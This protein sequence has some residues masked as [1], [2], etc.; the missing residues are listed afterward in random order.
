MSIRN[1]KRDYFAEAHQ[2]LRQQGYKNYIQSL[3]PG[4]KWQNNEY[5]VLNPTRNDTTPSSFSINGTSGKWADFATDKAGNDLIG[6]TA[7]IRNITPIEACFYIGAR[8]HN[9]T[10]S[11]TITEYSTSQNNASQNQKENNMK[12][13]QDFTEELPPISQEILDEITALTEEGRDP[14]E[15]LSA[16][17]PPAITAADTGHHNE[18]TFK[19]FPSAFFPYKN[20]LGVTVGYIVRWDVQTEGGET[21]KGVRP[22]IYDFK[23]K[24]WVSKFFGSNPKNSRPLYNLPQIL[25]RRDATVLIVEGEKTC[26]AAKLLFPEFVATTSSGGAQAVKQTEWHWLRGRNVIISPD[27]GKAGGQYL[28]QVIK[29][30]TKETVNSIK[31]LEPLKL[32]NYVVK[33]EIYSKRTDPLPHGYDLADSLEE[34]WTAELIQQA[35]ADKQFQPFFKERREQIIIRDELRQNEELHEFG[36]KT[37]KL[38][39]A[40]LYIQYFIQATPQDLANDPRYGE[41]DYVVASKEAWRPLC[42]YLK[43]THRVRDNDNSWGMLVKFKDIDNVERETFLKR[44]DWL[45]EK[46]AVEILQD[47]G[48]QLKGLDKK[49]FNLINEYLNEFKPEIQAIGVNMVGWQADNKTY[50]LPF[51]DEPRN[52]YSSA[53]KKSV[54]YILQ[55]KG[56]AVRVLKKKGTL[57]EWKRTVGEVC[58]GNH[59]HSFSILVSLTPI[60]LKLLDEEGGFVHYVGSSSIGKSTIL[61]VSKSVWGHENL[62]SFRSTHNSL[63]GICKNSNDGVMFLDEMGEVDAEDLFK[64]IYMLANGVTKSRA[65]TNGNVKE[66]TY[67]TVLAQSTGEIGLEAKLAEKR[68]QVKGGLLMRMAELDAD[69][70]KGLN[71]FDVLNINPDT[72]IR[73]EDGKAQAEYLKTHAQENYGVV[74]DSFLQK[75]VIK[76]DEYKDSLKKIKAQWFKRKLN[77]NE[78]VELARMAKRFS[79]VFASGVIASELGIIPHSIKE[80]EECVDA[81]FINWLERF[82]GDTP[83]ELKVIIANLYK[84]CIENQYSRFQ[85]AHPTEEEKVNL[86]KDRAGYWKTEKTTLE[87]GKIESILSEY[88]IDKVVFDR[89]IIKGQD[90]KVFYPLLVENGFI[91]KDGNHYGCKRR[92]AK[93]NSQR[94]IVVPASAFNNMDNFDE[95]E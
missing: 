66:T 12:I 89:E 3:L 26:E 79:T 29:I 8:R 18:R 56:R 50:M 94:F 58:R 95:N 65:D 70:G 9:K 63:E 46:G 39:Y 68:I 82:G 76:V 41:N 90:K 57:E 15:E 77:G 74:I 53:D 62:G 86:P 24:K 7:Y 85:N 34:G 20:S 59:L 35:I 48:L 17:E 11:Q 81:M 4:G 42:G 1:Y 37:Y 38:T 93:E 28:E 80:I 27:E 52:C 6:L 71:T 36:S 19:G 2:L 47:Q 60:A 61:E 16:Q 72:G 92:P 32:G 69:R 67:F 78:G 87:D 14:A 23:E 75:V 49:N 43:P 22:Y 40:G 51:V 44:T 21:K 5:V 10:N 25:E 73:F 83:H 45:G 30:L 55:Q 54:E 13:N 64:I 91:L 88:W 31:I 33:D 84:L